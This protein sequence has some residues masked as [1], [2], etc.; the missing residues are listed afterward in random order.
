ML[1][2]NTKC[3]PGL[4]I[5]QNTFSVEFFFFGKLEIDVEPAAC[6]LKLIWNFVRSTDK[7][8]FISKYLIKMES[9]GQE[10]YSQLLYLLFSGRAK[11]TNV[12]ALMHDKQQCSVRKEG[13]LAGERSVWHTVCAE[14][15]RV[16]E[17]PNFQVINLRELSLP[18]VKVSKLQCRPRHI[19]VDCKPFRERFLLNENRKHLMK[20]EQPIESARECSAPTKLV[21]VHWW[22][23]NSIAGRLQYENEWKS[24]TRT[25]R[26]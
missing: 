5:E 1:I 17:L 6:S 2:F 7:A 24:L 15:E 14:S 10:S 8:R 21:L 18:F 9:L 11:C 16:L 3:L 26:Y 23:G 12:G 25:R 13:Y 20:G 4:R 19:V 22:K